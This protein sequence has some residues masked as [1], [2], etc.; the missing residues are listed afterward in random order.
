MAH[1]PCRD[2]LATLLHTTHS[3]ATFRSMAQALFT[4]GANVSLVG[5]YHSQ[6]IAA[7]VTLH[8]FALMR[9]RQPADAPASAA[10]D[11]TTADAAAAAAAAAMATVPIDLRGSERRDRDLS[12]E[13]RNGA[14]AA[15]GTTTNGAAAEG[16]AAA[17][18]AAA[19][20]ATLLEVARVKGARGERTRGDR[21]LRAVWRWLWLRPVSSGGVPPAFVF[22]NTACVSVL[23]L[24]HYQVGRNGGKRR[25]VTQLEPRTHA[26]PRASLRTS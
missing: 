6:I 9:A 15:N 14:A 2:L 13:E 11:S 24:T 21:R 26:S 7:D 10:A 25:A 16:A 4:V 12:G 17:D 19:D 5:L 20:G 8:A 3:Y 1:T 23:M 22:A 18:G